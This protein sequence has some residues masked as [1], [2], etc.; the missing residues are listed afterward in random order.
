MA[1]LAKLRLRVG[2]IALPAPAVACW[3]QVTVHASPASRRRYT[4]VA[5]L[6]GSRGSPAV[7]PVWI[8]NP[9]LVKTKLSKVISGRCA[10]GTAPERGDPVGHS[11]GVPPGGRRMCSLGRHAGH[12]ALHLAHLRTGCSASPVERVMSVVTHGEKLPSSADHVF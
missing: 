2:L 4:Q 7:V 11:S 1:G 5:T 9:A 6:R 3:S 10:W 8:P 12:G